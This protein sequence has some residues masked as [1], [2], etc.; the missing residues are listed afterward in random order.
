MTTSKLPSNSRIT[1]ILILFICA[2][3][4]SQAQLDETATHSAISIHAT[5]TANAPTATMTPTMTPTSTLTP[6]P[7]PTNTPTATST[8][9]PTATIEPTTTPPVE[10]EPFGSFS[11]DFTYKFETPK[12]WEH[13]IQKIGGGEF[14]S[15]A[16]APDQ[17]A[18]LEF[19]SGELET[20][21]FGET[22]LDEYVEIDITNSMDVAPN[23]TLVTQERTETASG[24][25]I[26][27]IVFTQ[28]EGTITAQRMIYVHEERVA[29]V[30]TYY[31]LTNSYDELV[32]IFDYTFSVFDISE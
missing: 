31:T 20:L 7:S 25:P 15:M 27:I 6:S 21:G 24:L 14:R 10:M 11:S 3:G 9:V 23:F 32:P 1:L 19:Y 13:E 5:Q 29:I 12:G 16:T 30:L 4:P 26:E 17:T 2:C 22:T 18:V 28:Q 8:L